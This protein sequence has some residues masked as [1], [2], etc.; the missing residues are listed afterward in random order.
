MESQMLKIESG[1]KDI[2]VFFAWV[3]ANPDGFVLNFGDECVMLHSAT[4]G[5]YKFRER[6]PQNIAPKLCSTDCVALR[7]VGQREMKPFR[8]CHCMKE[9]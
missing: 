2:S 6:G 1:S 8:L 3:G 5:H 9:Q 4:C 7:D